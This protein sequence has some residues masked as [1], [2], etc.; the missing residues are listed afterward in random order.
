MIHVWITPHPCGPFAALEGVGAGVEAEAGERDAAPAL[1]LGTTL[2][3][4]PEDL[5]KDDYTVPIGKARIAREGKDVS[6]IT[7][8]ATVWKARSRT[9]M[10][11]RS[12]T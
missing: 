9:A 3:D 4:G 8:A 10:P 6:I 5:P 2:A 12:A 1:R 7:Y 11:A